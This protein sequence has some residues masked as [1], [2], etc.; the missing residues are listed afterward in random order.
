MRVQQL[1]H[2][3]HALFRGDVVELCD[4]NGSAF[5][6]YRYDPWG[7]PLGEGSYAT[8]V[9]TQGTSLVNAT[10]AG[11]IASRQVLRYATYAYD[12]ES[13]LYYCSARYYDPATRQWTSGDPAKADGE[14]SAYQYCSGDPV[15][16]TD[17]G[18]EETIR[19]YS[20]KWYKSWGGSAAPRLYRFW[21]CI[22]YYQ[23]WASPR[24][25]KIAS[26][27]YLIDNRGLCRNDVVITIHSSLYRRHEIRVARMSNHRVVANHWYTV[28]WRG[29]SPKESSSRGTWTRWSLDWCPNVPA[30][31]WDPWVHKSTE[32]FWR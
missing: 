30:H 15:G 32:R 2:R 16:A 6:A 18:G 20:S 1:G 31:W 11:Q 9:W 29:I 23:H 14:E 12:A 25:W 26:V 22:Y 4:A 21:A 8:G 17:A 28:R 3:S 24:W 5:A 27:S 10:L 13:G 19:V 7:S